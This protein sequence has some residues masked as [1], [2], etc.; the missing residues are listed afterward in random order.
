M[1]EAIGGILLGLSILGIVALWD[2]W[3]QRRA[4]HSHH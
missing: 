3:R 4:K 2:L 1:L